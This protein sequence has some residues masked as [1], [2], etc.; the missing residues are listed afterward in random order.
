MTDLSFS[1]LE[2][3]WEQAGGSPSL[4]SYAAAT[5]EVESSGNP[6][7]YNP[8]SASGLMQLISSNWGDIPGGAANRFNALDNMEGA[9]KLSG[10]T[11]AGLISNWT[12]WET[13]PDGSPET[14]A[15]IEALAKQYGGSAPPPPPSTG[16]NT[17]THTGQQAPDGSGG[18]TSNA[19]SAS[20][21]PTSDI[22]ALFEGLIGVLPVGEQYVKEI[23]QA[24]GDINHQAAVVIDRG[25]QLFQPG[26]GYRILFWIGFFALA[27][28]AYRAFTTSGSGSQ[29]RTRMV[30]V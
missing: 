25:F 5:A 16:G 12:N 10:D 19:P 17:G 3:L 13:Q 15:T 22:P 1:Q 23:F 14:P 29:P 11:L 26:Q 8:S 2:A 6:D 21:D 20:G 30:I 7:A 27:F 4:A 24:I 28:L 18:G 9:V